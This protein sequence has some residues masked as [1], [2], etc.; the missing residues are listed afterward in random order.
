MG[1]SG[2]GKTTLLNMLT[3]EAH[4]GHAT[5]EIS[6]NGRPL[7]PRLFASHCAYQRQTDSLW[8]FLT[9]REHVAIAFALGCLYYACARVD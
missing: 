5:G 3:L 1:P 4:G 7:T 8:D 9:C 6:I 2:A